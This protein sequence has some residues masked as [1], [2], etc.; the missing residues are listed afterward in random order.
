MS[1]LAATFLDEDHCAGARG[2]SGDEKAKLKAIGN[3]SPPPKQ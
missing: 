3:R 1:T 2:L